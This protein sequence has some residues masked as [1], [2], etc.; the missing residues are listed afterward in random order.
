MFL[1]LALL[2]FM[3]GISFDVS[4]LSL[5]FFSN[6]SRF[7]LFMLYMMMV[8]LVQWHAVRDIFN[9]RSLKISKNFACNIWNNISTIFECLILCF[10][11]FGSFLL[12]LLT[13]LYIFLL[14]CSHGDIEL[15]P[16]PNKPKENYLFVIG[17]LIA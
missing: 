9:C 13:C 4:P 11:Y 7:T 12:S 14:L 16:G 10:Q 2:G 8:S 5:K 1:L 15:N 6:G 17:I 3:C